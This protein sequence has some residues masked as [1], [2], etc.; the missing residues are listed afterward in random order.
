MHASVQ[1]ALGMLRRHQFHSSIH[2]GSVTHR[3]PSRHLHLHPRPALQTSPAH[4]SGAPC[5]LRNLLHTPAAAR[6]RLHG[7]KWPEEWREGRGRVLRVAGSSSCTVEWHGALLCASGIGVGPSASSSSSL[8]LWC[9]ARPRTPPIAVWHCPS[10]KQRAVGKERCLLDRPP[11]ACGIGSAVRR[12]A[13][14][15]PLGRR[16]RPRCLLAP[17]RRLAGGG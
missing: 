14:D 5:P 7:A 10:A 9:L 2:Q 1:V 8:S 17:E 16:P 6:S 13:G 12:G 15:W 11:F 3:Q 4:S